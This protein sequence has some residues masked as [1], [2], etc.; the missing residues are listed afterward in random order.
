VKERLPLSLEQ[1]FQAPIRAVAVSVG[2]LT[3][4]KYY[5]AVNSLLHYLQAAHP[6]V[7]QLSQLHRDPHILGWLR[8]MCEK[9]HPLSNITRL[10]YILCLR[11]LLAALEV[12]GLILRGDLP[13]RDQ[14]LPRPLSPEDDALLDRRLRSGNDLLSNALLLIRSTGIRVGECVNLSD[15]CLRSLGQ[16]KWA[17][18]VPLGKLH[19]ERWVPVDED[20]RKIFARILTLRSNALSFPLTPG[21]PLLPRPADIASRVYAALKKRLARTARQAGCSTHVTPH[22]LRHTYA[23][24]MLRAG[25]SLPALKELLGHKDIRMTLLYVQVTQIDLQR[26]YARARERLARLHPMPP[27]PLVPS[28]KPLMKDGIQ[29]I[30]LSV[31]STCHLLEMYRRQLTN[32]VL[33]RT[34]TRLANRLSKVSAELR[35]LPASSN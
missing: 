4:G 13:R 8:W 7:H 16:D 33:R 27:L 34:L 11:R 22:R 32:P 20:T 35:R 10:G 18:H 12:D 1:I 5:R 21:G 24:E 25:V 31:A 9:E 26:E 30:T 2:P 29:Q 3:I 17:L 28:T 23:T 6:R 15:D 19:T 14:Y